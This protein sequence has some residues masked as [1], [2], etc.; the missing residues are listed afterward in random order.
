MKDPIVETLKFYGE[1]V[2][3][4]TYLGLNY[5]GKPPGHIHPE[6][7]AA[8]PQDDVR[9]MQ[10]PPTTHEEEK[11]EDDELEEKLQEAKDKVREKKLKK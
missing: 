6:E 3:R 8:L 7:E 2:N 10:L 1:P 11:A 4:E 5:L 9:F